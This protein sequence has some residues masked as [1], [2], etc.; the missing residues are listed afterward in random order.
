MLS[1]DSI[2]F[3]ESFARTR[4]RAV[5]RLL[6]VKQSHGYWIGEL[7][8]SA[9]S[10]ATAVTALRFV[11]AVAHHDKVDAGCQWLCRTQLPDGSWGDTIDSPGNLSTTVLCWA[12]LG[13]C[14]H[15]EETYEKKT[16]LDA[17]FQKHIST[18]VIETHQ[19]AEKWIEIQAGGLSP[20]SIACAIK[21]SYGRDQTFSVPILTMAALCGCF[22]NYRDPS[23]WNEVPQLPFGLAAMP[24]SWFRLVD[25]QVVSYALPALIAIGQVRHARGS[26]G[27]P[28]TA[29]LREL[30]VQPTLRV[31]S[32][33][34]PAGGGFL[35]AVPLTSFVIMSLAGMDA[36]T[37]RVA[38]EG[39]DF[40][41]R[42]MRKDGSWPIDTN[43]SSWVT[44]QSIVAL[45][46]GGRLEGL[47]EQGDRDRLRHSIQ[48]WQWQCRH[49]STGA[50][51]GGWAWTNLPGGVP[52]ADDTSGAIMA[53]AVLESCER[54]TIPKE[55][56]QSARQGLLW[57]ADLANR[58]G[59]IPTFCRGWNR[60]P[61]DTSCADITAHFLRAACAW[62]MS[63]NRILTAV[64]RAQRYLKRSQLQDGS[65]VPLWFGNQHQSRHLNPTYGTSKVVNA[66]Y[67][68]K[69][70]EW[71]CQAMDLDGGVG[72]GENTPPSIEET[73]LTVETLATVARVSKNTQ[74]AIRAAAA[75]ERGVQWLIER[76]NEGT[77]F[78]AVPIG[79]Y[80]A[81]LWYSERL[82]PLIWS[83]AAFEQASLLP[84][85]CFSKQNNHSL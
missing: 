50:R 29:W 51:S 52:D 49:P 48:S 34:Q 22:G 1:H 14:L 54:R 33:I 85:F 63:D 36:A 59:G 61:F 78:D 79:L 8:S 83:V 80:F 23:S 66:T 62:Q 45:A 53:L 20:R 82:Y 19:R 10:T 70:A 35:E 37:H 56:L 6:E 77:Q 11:D 21:Q 4:D 65:W 42:S 55:V 68:S 24:Q 60:L 44:T 84:N 25:M 38:R 32:S 3:S 64:S 75:V 31:L 81:K 30:F 18:S 43:V 13:G 16:S 72:S 69:G 41:D 15:S 67:D 9:L 27:N 26:R 17:T 73:S 57:L 5:S 39:A 58:D 46:A 28:C 7:S 40:L 74:T 71:L 12:A 2:L 76:T 47:V